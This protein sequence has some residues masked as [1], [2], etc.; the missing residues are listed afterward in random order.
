M[1]ILEGHRDNAIVHQVRLNFSARPNEETSAV[2]TDTMSKEEQTM[3]EEG[4]AV[5]ANEYKGPK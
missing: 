5:I 3:A 1:E 2:I 4:F